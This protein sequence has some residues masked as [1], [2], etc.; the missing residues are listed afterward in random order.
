MITVKKIGVSK[1]GPF[2][3]PIIFEVPK[4]ITYIYGKNTSTGSGN[5]VGKSLF[6]NSIAELF[7]DPIVGTKQ[8][9][10]KHGKKFI[11]FDRDGHQVK[12]VSDCTASKESLKLFIDGKEKTGRIKRNTVSMLARVWPINEVEYRTYGFIDS[13]SH[14]PLARGSSAER[15]LFFTEF[16]N[17]EQVDIERAKI[18]KELN[19]LD[20]IKKARTEIKNLLDSNEKKL[21]SIEVIDTKELK[22][23]INLELEKFKKWEEVR[24]LVEVKNLLGNNIEKF[25][26]LVPSLDRN[27][28]KKLKQKLIKDRDDAESNK[29]D[30]EKYL[31]YVNELTKYKKSIEK[32]D[33]SVSI[34][35]LT[36]Y[37]ESYTKNKWALGMEKMS[38]PKKPTKPDS[39]ESKIRVD[40][41]KLKHELNHAKKFK[42]GLCPECGSEVKARDPVLIKKKLEDVENEVSK[43]DKYTREKQ[44]YKADVVEF[45][46]FTEAYKEA[47]KNKKWYKV[48]FERIKIGEAPKKVSKVDGVTEFNRHNDITTINLCLPHIDS[49]K[50]A[51]NLETVEEYNSEK[52]NEMQEKLVIADLKNKEAE[53]LKNS[54]LELREKI[55]SMSGELAYY[56]ELKILLEALADKAIKKIIVNSISKHLMETV[57]KYSKLVFPDYTF[58]FDWSESQVQILVNRKNGI[59]TDVRKLSGAES[60]IFT[61]ILVISLLRFVPNKKRMSMIVLDEP[62]ASFHD[63]TTEQLH[64]IL[65]AIQKIIPSVIIITPK[66]SERFQ[67][68]NEMT[69]LRTKMG[70]KLVKNHPSLH[71]G[72]A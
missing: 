55:K 51:I 40:F 56:K 20:A 23:A 69:V 65:P 60:K 4:G 32:L 52:L 17:L 5:A 62:T 58:S 46:R 26:N 53:V 8:D 35:E 11:E 30:H 49:I 25:V 41:E 14:H 13:V 68:A 28:A 24:H 64:K 33:M 54:S 27:D 6:F 38:M 34:E 59:T 9:K 61:L 67:G 10:I 71:M 15:K 37:Y 47:T 31:V 57:N 63:T 50:K 48:Y 7:Y 21:A 42:S 19:R 22:K 2:V 18:R 43:W 70:A 39:D 1:V 45:E 36:K 66:E 29:E 12:I 44:K 3:K 72:S 16:F